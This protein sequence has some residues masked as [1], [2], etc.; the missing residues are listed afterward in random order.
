[1]ATK[2]RQVENLGAMGD[3][4]LRDLLGEATDS[5][6]IRAIIMDEVMALRGGAER[7][8]RTLRN[9]WYELVKPILSRAGIVNKVRKGGKA[10]DWASLLSKYLAELV[11]E[12]ETS[13]EELRIVDGSRRRRVARDMGRTI[14][15]VLLVGGHFPWVILFVEKAT[16]WSAVESVA[17]LYGVSAICGGGQSSFACTEN[18]VRA[19]LESEAY[20][21]HRREELILLSLTDYDPFGY[22]IA[23]TQVEQVQSVLHNMGKDT[24]A[25]YVER[26]GL[27]P[28]QLTAEERAANA[29]EPKDKGLAE[30]YRA[31]GGV[32][33]SCLGLELDALSLSGLRRIYAEGVERHV[34][35]EKRREDLRYAFVDLVACGLLIDDFQAKREAMWKAAFGGDVWD[36]IS[37]VAIPDDLFFAAAEAGADYLDPVRLGL[38]GEWQ[39][40]AERVMLGAVE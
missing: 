22:E 15:D 11:R 34:D 5:S 18:T 25:L 37:G 28:G 19:I 33:G 2:L 12:G 30:W 36:D 35:I 10:L 39:K 8:S 23:E 16:V 7:E 6:V 20:R 14:A 27:E 26:L 3:A 32:D 29:Y 4:E 31:T 38:F 24:T 21:E 13:Y 9:V 17:S 1:M 40:E